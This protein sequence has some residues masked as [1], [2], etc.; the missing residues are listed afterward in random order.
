MFSLIK[1]SKFRGKADITACFIDAFLHSIDWL[2][3]IVILLN[4]RYLEP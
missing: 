4:F 3:Y 1:R 2:I